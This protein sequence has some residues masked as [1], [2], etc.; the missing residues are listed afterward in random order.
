[1]LLSTEEMGDFPDVTQDDINRILPE[2]GFGKFAILSETETTFIQA[3]N[4]WQP[5]D[6]CR[7][8]I[9]Q[10]GS[11]PWLLEYRDGPTGRQ[12]RASS[13]VTLEQ[14]RQ[15]FALYLAGDPSWRAMFEWRE[16]SR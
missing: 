2:D 8:F 4:D 6:E 14:V 11:D 3:G 5:G 1:M 15:A 9:Q 10:H 13:Q 16:L 7:A 12:Y